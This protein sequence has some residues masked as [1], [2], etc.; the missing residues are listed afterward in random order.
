MSKRDQAKAKRGDM[1]ETLTANGWVRGK[2]LDTGVNPWGGRYVLVGVGTG[3]ALAQ[4]PEWVRRA[5]TL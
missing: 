3:Q 5:S 4:K 2:M 1:V